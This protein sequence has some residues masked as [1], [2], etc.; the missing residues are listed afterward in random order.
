MSLVT[1]TPVR[2]NSHRLIV[3]AEKIDIVPIESAAADTETETDISDETQPLQRLIVSFGL[4]A[5]IYLIIIVIALI[6]NKKRK[7]SMTDV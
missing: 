2:I 6:I 5:L 7:E 1:C 4:T 3:T